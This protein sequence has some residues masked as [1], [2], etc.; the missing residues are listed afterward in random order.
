MNKIFILM[1]LFIGMLVMFSACDDGGEAVMGIRTLTQ[2][3]TRIRT[4]TQI[5]IPELLPIL[6]RMGIFPATAPVPPDLPFRA[7][8]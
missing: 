2:T 5:P 8:R 1:T 6:I 3:Q 4:L 7:N